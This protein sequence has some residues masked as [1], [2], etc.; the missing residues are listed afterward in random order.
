MW[1]ELGPPLTVVKVPR[2]SLPVACVNGLF[3]G[4]YPRRPSTSWWRISQL[5]W[6]EQGDR[7]MT[8]Q[9]MTPTKV[10]C[11][12]PEPGPNVRA[13]NF[14]VCLAEDTG[15]A[16]LCTVLYSTC[17]DPRVREWDFLGCVTALVLIWPTGAATAGSPGD[18]YSTHVIA[19][20][21]APHQRANLSAR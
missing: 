19:W 11:V 3:G 9:Y 15:F 12:S 17:S 21:P 6:P 13:Q 2:D 1:P 8:L 10:H 7:P 20:L 18:G 5:K 16:S 14:L 4:W